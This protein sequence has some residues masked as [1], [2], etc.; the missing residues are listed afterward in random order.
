MMRHSIF[1]IAL[2][3]LVLNLTSCKKCYTCVASDA[4]GVDVYTYPT[5]CGT[6]KD[7]EAYE[8]RC[9]VEFGEFDH[10]CT[11]TEE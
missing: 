6:K 5:I 4:D 9:D 1:F 2:L 8:S 11:C 3:G 10:T 7:V